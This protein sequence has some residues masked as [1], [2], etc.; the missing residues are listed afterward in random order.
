VRHTL[1]PRCLCRTSSKVLQSH[2][3]ARAMGLTLVATAE[4]IECATLVRDL[5]SPDMTADAKLRFFRTVLSA[6]SVPSLI[7]SDAVPAAFSGKTHVRTHSLDPQRRGGV[8]ILPREPP[9]P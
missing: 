9:Y 3:C 7:A 6:N 8:R 5:D 1:A 4:L 2:L